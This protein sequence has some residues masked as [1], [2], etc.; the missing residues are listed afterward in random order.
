VL[1]QPAIAPSA[2]AFL[3]AVA[4]AA[5]SGAAAYL[6]WFDRIAFDAPK[7]QQREAEAQS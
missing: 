2:A 1:Y 7:E 3:V 6:V 5:L 4:V